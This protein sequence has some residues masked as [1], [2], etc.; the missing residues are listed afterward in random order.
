MG[1]DILS[2]KEA[3]K[4]PKEAMRKQ[5]WFALQEIGRLFPNRQIIMQEQ[6][7]LWQWQ[8]APEDY[9]ENLDYSGLVADGINVDSVADSCSHYWVNIGFS[10]PRLACK[11]CG[12]DA[13]VEG[14]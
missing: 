14:T 13:P 1:V 3:A 6:N 12:I 2:A 10:T 7:G 8:F 4:V 11:Y 9:D 5:D